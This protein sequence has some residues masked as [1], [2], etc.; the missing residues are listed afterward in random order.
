MRLEREPGHNPTERVTDAEGS[1]M[2]E[3]PKLKL[4]GQEVLSS[5]QTD[6]ELGQN[7]DQKL[8]Y[9]YFKT[10]AKGGKSLIQSCKDLHLNRVVCYK[11]LLPEYENDP[12]EQTRLLREA[13]V[14]AL[15]QH[16][17]TV[18]TYEIGRD[19]KGHLYFTMKLVHGYTFREI[20]DYRERYDLGQLVD[21]IIQVG[22]A[23]EY[24]HSVGVIHRDLKPENILIGPYGEVLLLDWG[25]AKV[26]GE[27][28]P[29]SDENR[30][31]P[32]RESSDTSMTGHQKL[33]GTPYY[34]APE[35]IERDPDIDSRTDIYNLGIILY[36]ALTGQTPAQGERMDEVIH[37]TL[38][39]IPPAPS[40]LVPSIPPLLEE[41]VMRCLKKRPEDRIE[42]AGE[43]VRLLQQ[44]W[45]L[46]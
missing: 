28:G 42:S 18:P 32:E 30:D 43:L 26:W 19:R 36:E 8:R 5:E 33:Q 1:P 46:V 29:L 2:S 27:K 12:I 21:T 11:S 24:A 20:L 39:D 4:A 7:L 31:I 15:L 6:K 17:N 10:V 23:L 25:L 13:R 16:P 14:S 41:T 38:H 34:M 44:N 35:Q 45:A 40:T 9:A 3:Y 22:Y 37:S